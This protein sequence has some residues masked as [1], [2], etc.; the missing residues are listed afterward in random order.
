MLTRDF[1]AKLGDVSGLGCLAASGIAA[2]Q[3]GA[4]EACTWGMHMGPHSAG[5]RATNP[6]CAPAPACSTH[7]QV[8]LS[9]AMTHT[10][11]SKQGGV[12]TFAWVSASTQGAQLLGGSMRT[13]CNRLL[14]DRGPLGDD[15]LRCAAAT[16]PA[17]PAVRSG[18]PAGQ[19]MYILRRRVL[20]W[21]VKASCSCSVACQ[22]CTAAARLDGQHGAP[23]AAA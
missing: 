22:W 14:A 6:I 1:T 3:H 15:A 13:G 16:T 23:E 12:G 11:A 19:A 7:V 17:C 18:G 5:L 9:K 20:I 21:Q 2:E 8:G 4:H 10:F